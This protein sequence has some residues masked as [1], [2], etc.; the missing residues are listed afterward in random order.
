ML[1]GTGQPGSLHAR[2]LSG[3]LAVTSL[4]SCVSVVAATALHVR[5]LPMF[6]LMATC[7]RCRCWP[8]L[9]YTL[10]TMFLCDSLHHLYQDEFLCNA[11]ASPPPPPCGE[12]ECGDMCDVMALQQWQPDDGGPLRICSKECP[13]YSIIVGS[14]KLMQLTFSHPLSLT[15]AKWQLRHRRV[16]AEAVVRVQLPLRACQ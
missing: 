6:C 13:T 10:C 3:M 11:G 5:I 2:T 4:I 15:R 12:A 8:M 9:L 1:M 7:S 16:A 14:E